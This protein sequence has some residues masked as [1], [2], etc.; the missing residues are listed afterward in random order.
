MEAEDIRQLVEKLKNLSKK[1]HVYGVERLVTAAQRAKIEAPS[2]SVLRDSAKIALGTEP[3]KQ[4]FEPPNR[5]TGAMAASEKNEVWVLD[6]ADLSTYKQANRPNGAD[7][8]FVCV[9][10][11]S[12]FMRTAGLKD[13][14]AESTSAVF[15][16]WTQKVKPKMVDTDGGGEFKGAFD[17]LL[18]S[19]NI[20][21][22]LKT[23]HGKNNIAIVDRKIQMLKTLIVNEMIENSKQGACGIIIL[24]P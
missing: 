14:K 15:S 13:A 24:S 7:Y 4:I 16:K 9:D 1:L 11:F 8:I 12:R 21:H 20:A 18:N 2:L 5:S 19:K 6:L 23:K 10:I 17:R 22:R 3:V